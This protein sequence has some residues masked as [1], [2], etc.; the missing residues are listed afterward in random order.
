MSLR[1]KDLR[2]THNYSLGGGDYSGTGG[3]ET[4]HKIQ[5]GEGD[6]KDR[7][8]ADDDELKDEL[9]Q[10]RQRAVLCAVV[11]FRE[12]KG[13]IIGGIKV[14][15]YGKPTCAALYRALGLNGSLTA[16]TCQV[17]NI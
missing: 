9:I 15:S 17:E 7:R 14:G 16:F 10:Q 1:Q 3:K 8:R 4:K 5:L 6:G 13:M 2:E 11:I 12:E